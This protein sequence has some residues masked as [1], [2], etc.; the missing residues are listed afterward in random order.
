MQRTGVRSNNYTFPFVL[1]ACASESLAL[2]G[3]LI[4]GEVIRTGFDLD[5]YV[6]AAL[7]DMYAKCGLVDD[8]RKVFDKMSKRDLVC[9]TAM[10]TAYNQAERAKDALILL[11]KMQQEGLSMDSIAA[12]SVSSAVGQLGD[13]KM[14]KSVHAHVMRNGFLKDLCVG[15]SIMA[16]YAKCTEI[17]K[18]R[19]LFN[20]MEERDGISWNSMLSAYTQNGQA[21]EALLLFDQMQ[22]SGA[23]PNPVTLLIMVSACAYLGSRQHGRRLHNLIIDSKIELD[24]T[25][26]NAIMDMYAKCGELETA[27]EIFNCS[28]PGEMGVS[29]WNTLISGYGMHGFGKEALEIF[30]Q[31]QK[32]GVQPDHITFTSILSACSHA[33][34]INEGRKCFADMAKFSVIPEAKHYACMVDLLGRAGLLIEA[35]DLIKQMPIQPNDDVWGALLLACRIHGRT[36]LGEIAA[37]NLFQLEPEHAGYYVLMSNLYAAS[38]KWQEVGKLRHDMKSRGLRKTAALSVIEVGK[39]VHGFHTAD[40]VNP[41]WRE[42]Y[43]E[44]ERLANEMKMAGYVP[45][46]ECVLDDL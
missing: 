45:D 18:A 32:E 8:C 43:R 38:C 46:H 11:D 31:M 41:C 9:W 24:A 21:S 14:A 13:S 30:S 7:V 19:L 39:E 36:E 3:K 40:Q 34:L 27:V 26:W 44:V 10:I 15:N 16:M 1:K 20:W 35:Y 22:A 33:G 17:E 12:V 42:V 6:E 25:H 4:H 28:R 37:N 23:T 29:S 5:V 2:Q